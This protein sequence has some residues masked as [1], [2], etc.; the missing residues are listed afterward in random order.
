MG[1]F[2]LYFFFPEGAFDTEEIIAKTKE[3][4]TV[5]CLDQTRFLHGY[6][7]LLQGL[8]PDI[9]RDLEYYQTATH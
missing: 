9:Y 1:V 7:D 8:E 2:L 5:S 3:E 6:M 4:L